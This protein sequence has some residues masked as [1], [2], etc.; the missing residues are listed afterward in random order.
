MSSIEAPRVLWLSLDAA[1]A[2]LVRRFCDEGRLPTFAELFTTSAVAST[3][4]PPGL[5]TGAVWPSLFTGVSPGR[6]GTYYN[7]QLRSGTY[8]VHEFLA[9]D[10]KHEPFW[11]PLGRAGRRVALFDVPKAPITEGLNGLQITDWGTHDAEEPTAS[12]P[13]RLAEEV[14]RRH[15]RSPF[16]RCDYVMRGPDR[17]G[18][19]PE[20]R[21]RE[22]L[23]TRIDTKVA[24]AF[25]LMARERWDLFAVGFGESHC[26]GHQCWHLHDP[27]HP[28]HDPA[29]LA[30][31]GDPLRD[32]YVALDRALGRLLEAA[33]PDT[34]VLVLLSHGMGAHYDATFLLDEVLRRLEGV[35]A[36]ARRRALDLL[37]G[38]WRRL[39]P[40]FTERFR[41]VAQRVDR[42]PDGPERARRRCFAV[43]TNSNC[44]GIRVNRVG[45]EPQG[46]VEPG[47]AYDALCAHLAQALHELVDPDTGRAVVKEVLRSDV[48]FPGAHVD[49]LPDLLVRWH[50]ESPIRAVESPRIG[51]VAGED[52]GTRRTGDHRPEG[53]L[54]AR[55]P[56]IAP[57]PLPEPVRAED[58]APTIAALLG[59]ALPGLDGVP[60]AAVAGRR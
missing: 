60:I 52:T 24:I 50:R 31:V 51:R 53:L 38:A 12:W 15:G 39:P 45:R 2:G 35:R 3:R 20:D 13:P 28:C 14:S 44:G 55:G 22:G 49:D 11:A 40:G 33:G 48:L 37:R 54:L 1:D 4:N 56:G 34:T 16:E 46:R 7:E 36:P 5:Y 10:I 59:V 32:V 8:Q 47:A 23:L 30:R 27:A 43:P 19:L 57:G 18:R 25:D 6:H 21:L 9:R 17:P 42:S 29:R 58:V 26:V 41:G